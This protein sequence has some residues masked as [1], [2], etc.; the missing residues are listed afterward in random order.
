MNDAERSKAL[1]EL[2]GSWPEGSVQR[3]FVEGAK[4]W[5]WLNNQATLMSMER[6]WVEGEAVK[7]YGDPL[8]S[9][10]SVRVKN[11]KL[12]TALKHARHIIEKGIEVRLMDQWP[13]LKTAIPPCIEEIDEALGN[14]AV[15]PKVGLAGVS[16]AVRRLIAEN[17]LHRSGVS[18]GDV[19]FGTMLGHLRDELGELCD[20]VFRKNG[21]W[22]G[23]GREEVSDV[24]GVALHIA[25]ALEM[26][27]E[28]IARTCLKKFSER[29]KSQ[30]GEPL[31]WLSSEAGR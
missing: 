17:A 15:D 23:K 4:Y 20:A 12:A 2:R 16:R 8:E 5:E 13:I 21:D 7:R 18:M 11:E 30:D 29:F 27:D 9:E 6:R 26:S 19:P 28:D 10:D 31:E 14:S 3:A 22:V 25:V 1:E 24:L